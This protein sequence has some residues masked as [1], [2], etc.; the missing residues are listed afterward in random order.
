MR[1]SELQTKKIINISDG[2]HI[3]TIMD[4]NIKED[5]KIDSLI[6]ESTKG[7]FS[8]SKENDSLIY[9]N[10]IT[11]IGEDVILINNNSSN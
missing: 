6:I 9:W 5:G 4:I 10:E 8:L 11:K 2:K 7:L 3:G 1:L